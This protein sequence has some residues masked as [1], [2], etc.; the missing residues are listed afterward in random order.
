MTLTNLAHSTILLTP[1]NYFD[2]GTCSLIHF[3]SGTNR[4]SDVSIDL[5]NS[6]ILNPPSAEGNHTAWTSDTYGSDYEFCLPT[7]VDPLRVSYAPRP[8]T[9]SWLNI[10]FPV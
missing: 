8:A 1:F 7:A 4:V 9:S 10:F 3:Q 5:L 6:V 2:Y